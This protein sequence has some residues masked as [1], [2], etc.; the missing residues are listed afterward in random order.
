MKL[1]V[2]SL[3][4]VTN[5]TPRVIPLVVG[6]WVIGIPIKLILG[7]NV[8]ISIEEIARIQ[9]VDVSTSATVG[10]LGTMPL[11]AL[12]YTARDPELQHNKKKKKKK[13]QG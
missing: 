2:R 9:T 8:T 5:P 10:K 7:E 4:P 13:T 3:R 11:T 6:G 12:S 1:M